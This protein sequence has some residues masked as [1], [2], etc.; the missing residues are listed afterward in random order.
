MYGLSSTSSSLN[1]N[2]RDV[3]IFRIRDNENSKELS[4]TDAL[5]ILGYFLASIYAMYYIFR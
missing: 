3:E 5:I 4:G 1:G 2:G